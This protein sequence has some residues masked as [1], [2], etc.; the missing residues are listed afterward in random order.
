MWRLPV[1]I[2]GRDYRH[3]IGLCAEFWIKVVEFLQQ[4]SAVARPDVNSDGTWVC[5]VGDGL[6]VFDHIDFPSPA[7]ARRALWLNG[8]GLYEDQADRWV[9]SEIPEHHTADKAPQPAWTPR[10]IHSSRKQWIDP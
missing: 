4:N 9:E 5:F 2:T 1:T 7:A 3:T 10:Q 8:F 6:R